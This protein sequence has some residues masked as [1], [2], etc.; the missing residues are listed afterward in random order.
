MTLLRSVYLPLSDLLPLEG[1]DGP[2]QAVLLFRSKGL[3]L[4]AV[5]DHAL[6]PLAC[7]A[8]VAVEG[9]GTPAM[10]VASLTTSRSPTRY[11]SWLLMSSPPALTSRTWQ[12]NDALGWPF[13]WE[14][15]AHRAVMSKLMLW[16]KKARCSLVNALFKRST[17]HIRMVLPQTFPWSTTLSCSR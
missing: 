6:L 11:T 4:T 9:E 8:H 10:S 7:P 3:E 15:R 5:P 12:G 2:Q 13:R 16:R 17:F 14:R 1:E